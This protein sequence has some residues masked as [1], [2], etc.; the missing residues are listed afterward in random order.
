MTR[1]L[2][3]L[4]ALVGAFCTSA[5]AVAFFV[6]T[7]ETHETVVSGPPISAGTVLKLYSQGTD[8]LN[9]DASQLNNVTYGVRNHDAVASATGGGSGALNVDLGKRVNGLIPWK[10]ADSYFNRVFTVEMPANAPVASATLTLTQQ[11]P[12]V[13]DVSSGQ[14]A[15]AE[16]RFASITAGANTEALPTFAGTSPA[17]SVTLAPGGKRQVNLKMASFGQTSTGTDRRVTTKVTVVA[18]LPD[19]SSFSYEVPVV[20]C[21]HHQ[22]CGP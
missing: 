2:A 4:A 13:P 10:G 9:G 8:P 21:N 12:T 16:M 17:A 14:A 6:D 20:F 22:Q 19:G 1:R 7:K 18:T 11:V 3:I 5:V 15:F